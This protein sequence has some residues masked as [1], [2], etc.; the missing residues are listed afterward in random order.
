[1]V[2]NYVNLTKAVMPKLEGSDCN[3]LSGS[4]PVFTLNDGRKSRQGLTGQN[5]QADMT[6][7]LS[8]CGK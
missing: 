4:I 7:G 1:V 6:P 3:V 2:L 5:L 8:E